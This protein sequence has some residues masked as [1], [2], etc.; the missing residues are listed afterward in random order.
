VNSTAD[1]VQNQVCPVNCALPLL[2]V[3]V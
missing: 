1:V 3:L 2:K